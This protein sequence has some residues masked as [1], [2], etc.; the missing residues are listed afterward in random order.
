MWAQSDA[1]EDDD[2]T[3]DSLSESDT[4]GADL[5]HVS[6]MTEDEEEDP[7]NQIFLKCKISRSDN[8]DRESKDEGVK[9]EAGGNIKEMIEPNQGKQIEENVE[10]KRVKKIEENVET[11]QVKKIEEK[12]ESNQVTQVEEKEQQSELTLDK[13]QKLFDREEE[14]QK[15][16]KILLDNIK[17][18]EMK[19][20]D[21]VT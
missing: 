15:E 12:V 11:K 4:E 10:P 1:A 5:S 9:K 18:L 20:N 3:D 7:K 21:Q 2:N 14:Q 19:G 17:K 16:I 6:I 13:V 8:I